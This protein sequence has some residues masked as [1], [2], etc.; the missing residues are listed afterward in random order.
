MNT[1]RKKEKL[2]QNVRNRVYTLTPRSER[3]VQNP[4]N[5]ATIAI[6]MGM[7]LHHP[8]QAETEY[9]TAKFIS[10]PFSYR[11]PFPFRPPKPPR[12]PAPGRP[13]L[14]QRTRMKHM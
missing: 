10:F 12:A 9:K 4:A 1:N 5:Y 2:L 13:D 6:E 8:D 11:H 3:K 14:A 7:M